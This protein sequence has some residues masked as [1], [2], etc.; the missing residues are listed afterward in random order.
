MEY[1]S[2]AGEFKANIKKRELSGYASAFG[3]TDSYGDIVQAGAFIKTIRERKDK[4][5]VLYQHSTFHPI[6]IPLEMLEDSYGLSTVS[7]IPDTQ[8]GNDVLSLAAAGVLT[9]MSIGFDT[10]KSVQIEGGGRE[11]L[12]VR[13]WEYSPVTFAANDLATITGVKNASDL[14]P[15]IRQLETLGAAGLKAGRVLSQQNFNRLKSAL[16]ELQ[17]IL[18][19]AEPSEDTPKNIE[20]LNQHS[21]LL[22]EIQNTRNQ[23]NQLKVV[24]EL[25]AAT[26]AL[27][28]IQ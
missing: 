20:P 10:V 19:D 27:R 6:G 24:E 23:A 2:H 11:L 7:F 5:K 26:R 13:L 21:N 22:V 14:E 28:G 12:E 16:E 15:F 4:I 1:K 9:E 17:Q 3:N 18:N 25:R 8:L